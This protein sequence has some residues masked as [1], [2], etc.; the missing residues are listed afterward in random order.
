[1]V[2]RT[3]TDSSMHLDDR[4][5]I[6]LPLILRSVGTVC[7]MAL[8]IAYALF[9][10]RHL[11]S[12]PIIKL[13]DPIPSTVATSTILVHGTAENI[14]SLSLDGR[15]IFTTDSGEFHETVTLP[16]GYTILTIEAVD[17]YGAHTRLLR[18]VVRTE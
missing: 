14:V 4:M 18:N 9:Q 7:I 11:I 1:V 6:S 15:P 2:P 5:Y 10:A 3:V 16:I 13:L 17:R 12:G 8:V